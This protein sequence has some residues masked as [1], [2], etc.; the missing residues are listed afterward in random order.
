MTH[1][2]IMPKLTGDLIEARVIE[3][4]CEEGQNVREGD[5]IV[6]LATSTLDIRLPSPETGTIK[7][8]L[9]D[10]GDHVRE[11]DVLVLFD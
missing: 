5:E 3:W 10:E 4:Y 8:I 1:S 2:M 11:G 6:H 9:V 7:E